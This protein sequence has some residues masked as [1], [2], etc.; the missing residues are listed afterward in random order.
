MDKIEIIKSRDYRGTIGLKTEGDIVEVDSDLSKQLVE[1][2]CARLI[3][4]SS[5]KRVR[6][7]V[8]E[9]ESKQY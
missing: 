8:S 2:G 7:M 1:Q 4:E 9:E 5:A 6:K 3:L